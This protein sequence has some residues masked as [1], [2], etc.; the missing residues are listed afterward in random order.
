MAS[1]VGAVLFFISWLI[2]EMEGMLARLTFRE[3]SFGT[4]F[5]GFVDNATYL[6]LFS[7]ITTG[8]Y[9][10]YGQRERSWGIAVIAGCILSACAVAMQRKALT[11]PNR[12]HEYSAR[13]NRLMETDSSPISR[14]TRQIH[15]F[16]KKGFAV[17]YVLLLV[18][19]GACRCFCVSP[20]SRQISPGRSHCMSHG[21]LD[22]EIGL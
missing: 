9:R 22:E 17:H 21:D 6:L 18:V 7:G 15:V 19:V 5:E 3:S 2:D 16:V 11:A 13:T 10:Q 20:Q 14:I 1:V 12:P 4:W 8:L